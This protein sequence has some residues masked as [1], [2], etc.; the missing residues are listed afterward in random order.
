MRAYL[1]LPLTLTLLATS[2]SALSAQ[3][4]SISY[5]NP[6]SNLPMFDSNNKDISPTYVS[7]DDINKLFTAVN[8]INTQQEKDKSTIADLTSKVSD[9]EKQNKDLKSSQDDLSRK[10]DDMSRK[11]K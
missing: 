1:V 3:V 8:Q 7:G 6:M 2:L 5:L 4:P 11:I 9:L 10:L